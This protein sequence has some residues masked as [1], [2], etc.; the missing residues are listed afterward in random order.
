[1]G[2]RPHRAILD[3]SS[4]TR[5]Y[6]PAVNVRAL[7]RLV[8][9]V[10]NRRGRAVLVV[11]IAAALPRLVVLVADRG[12]ILQPFT[13]G[14]KSDDIARTFL[15]SGTFGFIPG[16][17]TAYTQP[18]YSFFLIP[19]YWAIDRSWE[20]V[21]ISQIMVAVATALIVLEIGRRHL[22]AAAGLLAAL[23]VALHPYSLWH[24]VHVN[25]EILDGLLAAAI[26]LLAL[27][28]FKSPRA[29]LAVGLGVVFGLSILSNVRL[30]VLPLL[31]AA[32][33]LL[34]W[35][36]SRRSLVLVA[37]ML[38]ACVVTLAPW[39]I[40]N[41]I[42]VG[43]FA[44][45]TDSRALWEA[46][47]P[48]TLGVLRKG[49]W[50]DNVPLPTSFPPSAQDAG[51]MYRRQ[52][53]IVSVDECA[54]T[55]YYQHKVIVFWEHHP[56]EKLSLAVQGSRMLWNPVV[57]PPPTRSD[58]L[59]WLENL[60]DSVEPIY[61]GAVFLLALFGFFVVPRRFAVLCVLLLAYQ[62]ALA[63][64]FV[65]ATRYRVP[66]DFVAAL[67]AGAAIVELSQRYERRRRAGV[68]PSS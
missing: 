47:N 18:L 3:A 59:G 29:R 32:L 40:R 34:Y 52:G 51:R 46:N 31:V 24:D 43:C 42:E 1:M 55:A 64:V 19:L 27:E 4:G 37:A 44:L 12:T 26:F 28:L 48:L 67:L 58:A 57:S 63:I 22:S 49:S 8:S 35:R 45:T 66:W 50:I 5:P 36:P 23:I 7:G 53:R 21:G 38:V 20:V 17:P 16:H 68:V 30:T 60:R 39:V 65:G 6:T 62:W 61:I 56:G 54:Q 15:A 13:Y 41:R 9:N 25:R 11:S 2:S 33:C 14:E 10:A